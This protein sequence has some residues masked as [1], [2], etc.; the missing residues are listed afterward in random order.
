MSMQTMRLE[1]KD[2]LLVAEVQ[3]PANVG[4]DAIEIG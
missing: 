2:G 3:L 1:T 4:P